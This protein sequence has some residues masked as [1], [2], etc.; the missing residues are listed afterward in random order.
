MRNRFYQRALG[1]ACRIVGDEERVR[2]MLDAPRAAFH[3]WMDGSE[4][5]PAPYLRMLLDFLADMES[6]ANILT[7]PDESRAGLAR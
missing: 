7:S 6:G 3:R 4:A 5:I 1:K 2:Q